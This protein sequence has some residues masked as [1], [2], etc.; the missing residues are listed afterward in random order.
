[1]SKF[2]DKNVLQ[3]EKIKL[4]PSYKYS[5]IREDMQDYM[6]DKLNQ[7]INSGL[8]KGTFSNGAEYLIISTALSLEM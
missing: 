6:F 1:M 8:I 7:L 3:I 5:F 2:I 4:H